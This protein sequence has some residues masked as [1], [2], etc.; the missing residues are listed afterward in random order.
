MY[1]RVQMQMYRIMD[2]MEKM[3]PPAAFSRWQYWQRLK[4]YAIEFYNV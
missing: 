1:T 4:T 2:N 3:M